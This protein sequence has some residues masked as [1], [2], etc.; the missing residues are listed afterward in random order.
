MVKKNKRGQL[1]L[2]IILAILL[3]ASVMLLFYYWKPEIFSMDTPE[4]RLER[5]ISNSLDAKIKTLSLSA[6]LINPTFNY[7]YMGKNY[8]F[9]CYTD[10]YY[11][12]CVNQEPF[13]TKAFEES[14]AILLAEEFQE[15]YDS[16]VDDLVRRG[17][18]VR[19]GKA[20]FDI[21]IE[22]NEIL[23]EIDAPLSIS[24]GG[25]TIGTQK[26]RYRHRTNLYELLMVAVSLIQFETYYGD[27]EQ[28]MQMFYYPNI[29][30]D[31][32]RR[33]DEVKVYTLT[34]KNEKIEY[35]FAVK[36]F[37]YPAGGMF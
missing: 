4:P 37:P 10:E 32:Q 3:V 35:R 20:V 15:C 11:K 13:L 36:S 6:G 33:G 2:F 14:L 24:S 7:M 21:S 12:P 5:C 29:L 26:Y 27:S 9:L 17:F 25:S 28:T 18:D 8:T 31:K 34:E 1:T 16:S 19:K 23:I 22:P 30:I